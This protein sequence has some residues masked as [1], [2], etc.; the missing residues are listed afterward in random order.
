MKKFT[1]IQSVGSC[2][3][4]TI[5]MLVMSAISTTFLMFVEGSI[6]LSGLL[7]IIFTMTHVAHY[8]RAYLNL[9]DKRIQLL[10][11]DVDNQRS[12][13]L[14]TEIVSENKSKE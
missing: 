9:K 13:L 1:I 3:M 2:V 7:I 5:A 12:Y 11:D 10:H 8:D 6:I 4:L 14:F